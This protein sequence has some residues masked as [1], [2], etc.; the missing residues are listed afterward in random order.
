LLREVVPGLRR[1][2]ILANI[3]SDA[4]VLDMHEVEATARTLGLEATALQIRR[5]EDIAPGFDEIKG[6]A[7]PTTLR[8]Q[9]ALRR[10]ESRILNVPSSAPAKWLG[11]ENTH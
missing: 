2:A 8:S 4:A 9:P 6:R 10:T 1:L 11:R 5:A 3:G 7:E